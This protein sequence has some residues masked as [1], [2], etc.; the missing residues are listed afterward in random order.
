MV[1]LLPVFSLVAENL[2]RRDRAMALT[3]QRR[4]DEPKGGNRLPS[5]AGR[6]AALGPTQRRCPV[7]WAAESM[8]CGELLRFGRPGERRRGGG[9]VDRVC[10]EIEVAGSDL[11]LVPG[12]RVAARLGVELGLLHVDVG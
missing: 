3:Q 9:R 7:K 10:N 1:V 11:A 2:R 4:A 5:T 12:R 6:T 8:G